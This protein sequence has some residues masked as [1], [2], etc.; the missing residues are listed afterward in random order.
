MA[1]HAR[2]LVQAN[3]VA[4]IVTA[5]PPAHRVP[6]HCKAAGPP[7][8]HGAAAVLTCAGCWIRRPNILESRL[9]VYQSNAEDVE[10]PEQVDIII[11]EWMG[12]FLLRESMLDS[13][14]PEPYSDRLPGA[15]RWAAAAVSPRQL[16]A[17]RA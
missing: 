11:S 6:L 9:Q 4:D 3:G 12:Y 16:L 5:R 10:L 15:R 17:T 13:A 1:D 14:R 2:T 7:R 8:R